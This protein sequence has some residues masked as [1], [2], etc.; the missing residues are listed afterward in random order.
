MVSWML[1]IRIVARTTGAATT[2][3][4]AKDD[5]VHTAD[6]ARRADETAATPLTKPIILKG[7]GGKGREWSVEIKG[8][9]RQAAMQVGSVRRVVVGWSE[10]PGVQREDICRARLGRARKW[11]TGAARTGAGGGRTGAV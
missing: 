1:L 9:R 5:R 11:P 8:V 2:A 4:P 6:G 7:G 10:E 3:A